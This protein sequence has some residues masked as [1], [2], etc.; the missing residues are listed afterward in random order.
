MKITKIIIYC[1]Y[2]LEIIALLT[3]L[4]NIT[5][6]NQPHDT[7]IIIKIIIIIILYQ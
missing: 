5:N 3:L 2:F 4:Q 6:Q 1:K 7:T